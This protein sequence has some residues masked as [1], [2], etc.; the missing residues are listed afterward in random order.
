MSLRL[1]PLDLEMFRALQAGDAAAVERMLQLTVP[2]ELVESPDYAAIWTFMIGLLE[3]RPENT[4]WVMR[5]VVD[6]DV[7]VGNAGFKGAPVDGQVELG[8]TV[9]PP[10]RRRGLAVAAVGL[11]LDEACQHPDV[12][13][14]IARIKPD[15]DASVGVVTK[16][17][18]VPDGDHINPRWGRQLQYVHPTPSATGQ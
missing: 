6:D 12:A 7:I 4:D 18:F 17:G 14:V 15:N 8:Y 16:A 10:H 13:R 1:A 5:L 9:A 3:G 11:L 2:V